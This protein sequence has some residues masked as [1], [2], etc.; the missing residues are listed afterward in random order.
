MKYIIPLSAL[1]IYSI[2]FILMQIGF[3]T[4]LS[5]LFNSIN[6]GSSLFFYFFVILFFASIIFLGF[7]LPEQYI[8]VILITQSNYGFIGVIFLT[9]ISIIAVILAA[10]VNYYLGYFFSKKKKI[11]ET[12]VNQYKNGNEVGM[13]GIDYKKLLLSMIHINTLALFMFEQGTRKGPKKLIAL[14]GF[15]NLPYYFLI[16]GITYY[17]K[18]SILNLAENPYTV[19][20]LLLIWLGYSIAKDKKFI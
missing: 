8:A 2:I 10:G 1:I 9:L 19:L 17:F 6:L 5:G 15:L 12:G 20:I 11:N 7:Y 16:I 14:T 18:D 4:E 3:L 13:S